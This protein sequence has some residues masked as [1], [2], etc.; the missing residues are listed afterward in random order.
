VHSI[1]VC[2]NMASNSCGLSVGAG[3]FVAHCSLQL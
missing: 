1:V 3:Q 2:S